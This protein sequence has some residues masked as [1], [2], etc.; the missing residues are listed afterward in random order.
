MPVVFLLLGKPFLCGAES[1]LPWLLLILALI[2][3]SE[4]L[5]P[6]VF[7]AGDCVPIFYWSRGYNACSWASLSC[8]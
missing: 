2:W 4:A 6:Q 5:P 1:C 7:A 8:C 3:A